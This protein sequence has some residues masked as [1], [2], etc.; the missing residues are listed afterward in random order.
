MKARGKIDNQA[1]GS[2]TI[3]TVLVIIL[4]V[5]AGLFLLLRDGDDSPPID[6]LP[7]EALGIDQSGRLSTDFDY[8]LL[9][10][11]P[12]G[13]DAPFPN[14][15]R[16]REY[17]LAVKL[18]P[19]DDQLDDTFA[20]S[21]VDSLGG[22]FYEE[23]PF[24]DLSFEYS[25]QRIVFVD[26]IVV[27]DYYD[28]IGADYDAWWY[29]TYWSGF[30]DD[31]DSEA[32]G[33]FEASWRQT[34]NYDIPPLPDYDQPLTSFG[35][36]YYRVGLDINPGAYRVVVTTPE[37][38]AD[39]PTGFELADL[40][41]Y[42]VQEHEGEAEGWVSYHLTPPPRPAATDVA[43]SADAVRRKTSCSLFYSVDNPEAGNVEYPAAAD[44]T[45]PD[46]PPLLVR[47]IGIGNIV[48]GSTLTVT[49]GPHVTNFAIGFSEYNE[50]GGVTWQL[51]D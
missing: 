42:V 29:K 11:D 9:G 43:I 39:D 8:L 12:T 18:Q 30:G 13:H 14:E 51:S 45:E 33:R 10:I 36:G 41:D 28:G 6:N 44:S 20:K 49:I 48:S 25:D 2:A 21:Y 23:T 1:T 40:D 34:Y 3:V 31:I 5:V 22:D 46:N 19:S 37:S 17:H 24:G 15:N 38:A 16:P 26:T 4:I 32:A 35:P 7:E 27:Y 47:H 50:C